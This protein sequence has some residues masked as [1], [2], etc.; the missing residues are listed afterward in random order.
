MFSTIR[1]HYQC[2]EIV[3]LRRIRIRNTTSSVV[4]F[5][6]IQICCIK[7]VVFLTRIRSIYHTDSENEFVLTGLPR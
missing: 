4:K 7:F 2:Y 5:V 1:I 3:H 6:V